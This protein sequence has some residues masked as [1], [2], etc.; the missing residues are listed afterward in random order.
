MGA[1]GTARTEHLSRL[2]SAR[3]ASRFVNERNFDLLE[4]F[5]A[6]ASQR[7][8]PM[9]ELAFGWLL[10]QP[11]VG[12]VIAGATQPEQ[13]D[14]NVAAGQWRLTAEDMAALAGVV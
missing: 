13:V 4:K 3:T 1:P 10:S 5:E 9:T 12:S 7:G 14:E 6:F 2:I 11:E 8:H